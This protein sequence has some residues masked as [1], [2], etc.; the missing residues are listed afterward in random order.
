VESYGP[1]LTFVHSVVFLT[2][3]FYRSLG[4]FT[5]K[6]GDTALD[7]ARETGYHEL[8]A[9]LEWWRCLLTSKFLNRACFVR[10]A[11]TIVATFIDV[12]QRF[13]NTKIWKV[14]EGLCSSPPSSMDGA[15][16]LEQ[17]SQSTEEQVTFDRYRHFHG[18]SGMHSWLASLLVRIKLPCIPACWPSNSNSS[19]S[20]SFFVVKF[21]RTPR[22][23][24]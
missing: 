18:H 2:C 4:V 6:D 12:K 5:L 11:L 15:S 20:L 8:V 10:S 21:Q 7:Y 24:A 16:S 3:S 9:L 13:T 14:P 19:S 17:H 23:M 22:L 1:L